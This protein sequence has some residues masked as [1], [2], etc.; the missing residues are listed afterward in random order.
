MNT[1]D[2]NPLY[3]VQE[4]VEDSVPSDIYDYLEHIDKDEDEMEEQ[5]RH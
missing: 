2:I 1:Y 3:D 4:S 5:V